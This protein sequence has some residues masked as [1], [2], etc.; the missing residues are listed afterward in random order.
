MLAAGPGERGEERVLGEGSP[1][2]P[3]RLRLRRRDKVGNGVGGS[4]TAETG[5]E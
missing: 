1:R 5:R 2:P 4:E 3:L